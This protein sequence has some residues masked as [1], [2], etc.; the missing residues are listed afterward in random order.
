MGV[1]KKSILSP[2]SSFGKEEYP[3]GEV[4]HKNTYNRIRM[5]AFLTYHPALRAPLLPG[6]R[7]IKIV[8]ITQK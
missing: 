8:W 6:G 7:G 5:N 4:K 1:T 3:Q 2:F